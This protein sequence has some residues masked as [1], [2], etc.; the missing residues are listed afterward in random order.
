MNMRLPFV[1]LILIAFALTSYGSDKPNFVFIFA[2]DMGWTGTSVEM[3]PGDPRTKSDYYLTPH[4]E[5]LAADGMR[6]SAAYAPAAMC[7]PSRAAV[8]TGKTPAELHITN[9]GPGLGTI[10][11]KLRPPTQLREF[12]TSEISIAEILKPAGYAS[13]YFGKWHLGQG[14]PGQHGFDVHDGSTSNGTPG[15]EPEE[16][17]KDVY[18]LNKRAIEFMKKSVEDDRPFYVQ[19]FHYAVH[20]PFTAHPKSL[21]KF[22]KLPKG[23]RHQDAVFGGMTWDLDVS[24]G[25]LRKEIENL[26]IADNTYIVFL[27]DNGAGGG[28]RDGGL[29]NAPLNGGKS[30]LYEGGIRVPMIIAGPGIPANSHS[31][32]SVTGSDLY[33]TFCEWAG[34]EIGH[35]IDG[36]SLATILG[37]NQSPLDRHVSSLLFHKP[38]YGRGPTQTPATAIIAGDYK[39]IRDYE[40]D[41]HHLF[42][43]AKDLGEKNDLA[44][45]NP[46]KLE[47][48]IAM[49]DARLASVNAQMIGPNPDYDPTAEP[50]ARRGPRGGGQGGR[51]G[52]RGPGGGQ[53]GQGPAN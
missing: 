6:F 25:T 47:T 34:V 41:R 39:L 53:R 9:P 11:N 29:N 30:T 45:A 15:N 37:G 43:L 8:L 33:P 24:I 52:Q 48:M 16:N 17:P 4:L 14:N 42:N 18:G 3:I 32:E 28:T 38:H 19:L 5:K 46:E 12:P 27:S 21:A 20:G 7:T 10:A 23:K 1:T 51:G 26:G 31:T 40:N 35:K 22:E 2:D 50:P 36:T 13:A 44:K 49:M